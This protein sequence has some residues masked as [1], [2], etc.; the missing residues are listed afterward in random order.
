MAG[1]GVGDTAELV[2]LDCG[3]FTVNT[4]CW[5][6]LAQ[7]QL[8]HNQT[9]NQTLEPKDFIDATSHEE[10][11]AFLDRPAW[12]H[13]WR[14]IFVVRDCEEEQVHLFFD[15]GEDVNEVDTPRGRQLLVHPDTSELGFLSQWEDAY[16][17]S[18]VGL[19]LNAGVLRC[20]GAGVGCDASCDTSR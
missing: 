11:V 17:S 12:D 4:L 9:H 19:E 15:N 2:E 1:I 5:T 16:Y 20:M 13:P 6:A 8:D 10:V 18:D 3:E 7:Q 14:R